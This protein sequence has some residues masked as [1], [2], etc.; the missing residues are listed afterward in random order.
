MGF[1]IK[2]NRTTQGKGEGG[3]AGEEGE[4]G[5][6]AEPLAHSARCPDLPTDVPQA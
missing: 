2:L 3:R 4:P 5:D 6:L 1:V